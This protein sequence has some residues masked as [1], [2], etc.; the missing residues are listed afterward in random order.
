MARGYRSFLH[1]IIFLLALLGMAW[2]FGI[3]STMNSGPY[4]THQWRQT[5]CLSITQ[6]YAEKGL[7]FLEPEIYW[8][9]EGKGKTMSEFP[10]VYYIVGKIWSQTGKKYWIYRLLNFSIFLLGLYYLRKACNRFLKDEIWSSLLVLL[11]FTSPLLAYYSNN[12]LMNVNAL[13][14]AFVG[15]YHSTRYAFDRRPGSLTYAALF[16]CL[17]GLLKITSLLLF[18]AVG[19]LLLFDAVKRKKIRDEW[20]NLLPFA[21]T[22]LVIVTWYSF[23]HLYNARHLS[24]VFLQGILPIWEL[25]HFDIAN[26]FKLLTTDLLPEYFHPWVFVPLLTFALIILFVRKSVDTSLKWMSLLVLFGVICYL[27]LFYQVFN[28]HDYYLIN[29][30]PMVVLFLLV[31]VRFGQHR[32]PKIAGHPVTKLSVLGLLFFLCWNTAVQTRI[33]YSIADGWVSHSSLISEEDQKYWEWFH[34][35]YGR[36]LAELE[37]IEPYLKSIGVET[38]DQV[39]SVPDPSIN[40]SLYLMNRA[41]YTDFEFYDYQG[42]DRIEKFISLGAKYLVINSPD[43]YDIPHLQ[44]YMTDSIGARGNTRIYRLSSRR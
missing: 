21:L 4:S 26:N 35:H 18:F 19:A 33:K 5:D 1:P 31:T 30:L 32:I 7:P 10:I 39:V 20:R 28:H 41:G 37:T 23:V 3:F 38:S 29:L 40:I 13:S 27:L 12:F 43:A 14:L 24:T 2:F 42:E 36:T 8:Q 9:G 22:L 15:A 17:A 44:P 11:V 34:W 25:D 6:N 16:F